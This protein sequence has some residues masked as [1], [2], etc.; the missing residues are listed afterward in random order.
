MFLSSGQNQ[1]APLSTW[2]VWIPR[3]QRTTTSH[4]C[5]I[6]DETFVMLSGTCTAG[7]EGKE[8]NRRTGESIFY[9]AAPTILPSRVH[10]QWNLAAFGHSDAPA[11]SRL[12]CKIWQ[13][14]S[15]AFRRH[16]AVEKVRKAVTT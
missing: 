3:W 14:A 15:S 11:D 12:L 10:R 9:R 2:I 6:E 8:D 1:L 4:P 16:P 13:K 7:I 5:P